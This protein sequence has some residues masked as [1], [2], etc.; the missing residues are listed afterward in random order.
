M[1]GVNFSF[2]HINRTWNE[3][4]KV[5]VNERAVHSLGFS[6]PEK[7]IGQKIKWVDRQL[8]ILGVVKDYH[9]ETLQNAISPMLFYPQNHDNYYSIRLENKNVKGVLRQ[10][11]KLYLQTFPSN[12]FEYFFLDENFIKQYR[13]ERQYG[14]IFFNA[15]FLAIFIACL[16]LFGLATFT[17]EARTKEIGI[18]KVLGASA[19]HIVTLIST[20]FLRLVLI[21][22]LIASPIAWYCCSQYLQNFAYRIDLNW[23]IF[24]IAGL[25]AMMI[26]LF[27]ITY[28]AIRASLMNPVESLRCE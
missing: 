19:S 4:D 23:W 1:A 7:A 14:S 12:P 3:V 22:F 11:E 26:A 25:L 6:S 20:D 18:R 17:V 2:S 24:A 15:S 16:G 9:H 13:L 27:T 21:S 10:L 28:Q 5:L 8:E